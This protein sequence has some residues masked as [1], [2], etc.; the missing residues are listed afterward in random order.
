MSQEFDHP[1]LNREDRTVAAMIELYCQQNHHSAPG[2]LC[3]ECAE[4]RAYTRARL[5]RCP[6]QGD[7]PTCANCAVHCYRPDMRERVRQV[8]RY[9]GPRMLLRHPLLA[10]IHLL[11]G[12]RPAPELPRRE[13]A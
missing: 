8:M 5:K 1:R 9:S 10:I 2:E 11:D 3:A 12:L 4:L 6:F 13:K 7:K